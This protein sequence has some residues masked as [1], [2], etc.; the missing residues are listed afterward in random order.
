V[1]VGTITTFDSLKKPDL[2]KKL[3]Q[4]SDFIDYTYY[5]L[6]SS[7]AMRPVTDVPGDVA[8][9][10][11]GAGSKW[12]GFTELGYSTSALAKSSEQQQVDFMKAVFENLDK[13]K[14]QVAFVNWA[15][16]ADS[17]DDVCKQYA[18]SQ[19]L[20]ASDAFCGYAAH[21]GLRTY[22]NVAKPAWD[23]L[24]AEMDKH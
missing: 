9:M 12:F 23:I 19:N 3:T 6:G 4:Y 22:D 16:L 1:Q 2:F 11:E 18:M 7:W 13:H 8:K 5:P 21:T 10:V 14:G 17:P 20:P 15:G 24:V